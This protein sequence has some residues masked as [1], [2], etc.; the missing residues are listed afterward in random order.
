I[1][2]RFLTPYHLCFEFCMQQISKWSRSDANGESVAL[3]FAEQREYKTNAAEALYDFYRGKS[4]WGNE[5]VSLTFA[6]ADAV[7]ALQAAGLLSYEINRYVAGNYSRPN[8]PARL[9]E[10]LTM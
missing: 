4:P 3:I 5:L 2:S 6:P 10:R 8:A 1:G 9:G 7:P